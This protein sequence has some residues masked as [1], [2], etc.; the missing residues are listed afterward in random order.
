VSRL[1]RKDESAL[2]QETLEA[3]ANFRVGDKIADVYL[4]FAVSEP[5]L[6]AYLGMETALQQGSLDERLLFVDAH[7]ESAQGGPG[8]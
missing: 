8:C 2:Q 7:H 5:A 6:R 1:K 3:L 4:D